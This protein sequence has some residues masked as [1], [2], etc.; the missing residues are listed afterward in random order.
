MALVAVL[1]STCSHIGFARADALPR[2]LV[3][4]R[5]HRRQLF[6]PQP[7]RQQLID[8]EEDLRPNVEQATGT[9]D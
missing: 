8:R 1:C 4:S 9:E 7:P 2:V 6:E 5:C 3:C